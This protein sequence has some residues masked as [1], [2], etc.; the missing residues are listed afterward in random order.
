VHCHRNFHHNFI[1]L[2]A[3][4]ALTA[5]GSEPG[6][7]PTTPE[8]SV[9]FQSMIVLCRVSRDVFKT[10]LPDEDCN[11]DEEIY[12]PAQK[13]AQDRLEAL[14]TANAEPTKVF[15]EARA[16]CI[17][18]KVYEEDMDGREAIHVCTK[19]IDPQG[20]EEKRDTA[21]E[22]AEEELIPSALSAL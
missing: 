10:P 8:Q 14:Y 22:K 7:R 9:A 12:T 15:K 11:I 4:T 3:L 13:A 2:L 21:E 5:C 18:D 20:L 1:A 19:L 16:E 6:K 17:A